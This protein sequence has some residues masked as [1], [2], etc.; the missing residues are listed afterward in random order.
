MNE[1]EAPK[2]SAFA[3]IGVKKRDGTLF[4]K[5]SDKWDILASKGSHAPNSH[6]WTPYLQH[7]FEYDPA[8]SVQTGEFWI[9]MQDLSRL[10]HSVQVCRI[11]SWDSIS[12]KGQFIR[13]Q[14]K[15]DE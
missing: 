2:G 4:V 14:K 12:I 8:Q 15:Q 9:T 11:A 6:L 7:E 5:M 13:R 1:E 10:F 3:I